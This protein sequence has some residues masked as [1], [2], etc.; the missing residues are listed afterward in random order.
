MSDL[1]VSKGINLVEKAVGEQIA[2]VSYFH[3]MDRQ[4]CFILNAVKKTLIIDKM[5]MFPEHPN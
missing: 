3:K 1:K 5:K 4:E 2:L